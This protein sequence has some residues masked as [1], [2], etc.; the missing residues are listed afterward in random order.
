MIAWLKGRLL[1][2]K[3][4]ELLLDVNSVGYRLFITFPTYESLPA[5]GSTTELYTVT[6]AREDS[7]TLYGFSSTNEKELFLKLTSV[8]RIGPKLAL[9][10]LSGMNVDKMRVAIIK[11]D[12]GTL[13]QTPGIGKKTAE[14]IVMELKDK[15]ASE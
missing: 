15:L 2:K 1:E 10:A 12:V 7:L 5:I 4:A 8:T 3:P 14:R 6:V 11:S 9:Q 13:S